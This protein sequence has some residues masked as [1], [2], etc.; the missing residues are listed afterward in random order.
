MNVVTHQFP[1][2]TLLALALACGLSS[3]GVGFNH[4]WRAAKNMPHDALSGAWEGSWNSE[5]TGHTGKLRA[6]IAKSDSAHPDERQVRYWASWKSILS[7]SFTTRHTFTLH[8]R[9]FSLTGRHQ[10]PNWVGGEY[11]YGGT[12]TA[13]HFSATYRS[14]FDHG[15]FEMQRAGH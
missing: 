8:G 4:D 3:C 13:D 14:A 1:L 5:A 12:A 7:A 2:H 9:H 15:K 10:M 11:T 6:I